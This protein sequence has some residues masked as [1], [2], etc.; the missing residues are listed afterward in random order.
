MKIIEVIKGVG[1]IPALFL[2]VLIFFSIAI[3]YQESRFYWEVFLLYIP[4]VVYYSVLIIKEYGQKK[5][6]S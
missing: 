1:I 6:S 3:S 4:I 2:C 5:K